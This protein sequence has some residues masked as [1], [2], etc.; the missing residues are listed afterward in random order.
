MVKLNGVVKPSLQ[1][2][3][4]YEL[5]ARIELQIFLEL[6]LLMEYQPSNALYER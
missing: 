5:L 4:H 1:A 6:L 2:L 3:P